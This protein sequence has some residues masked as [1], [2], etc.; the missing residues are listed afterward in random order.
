[1]A[2]LAPSLGAGAPLGRAGA[3]RVTAGEKVTRVVTPRVFGGRT[4]AFRCISP[5][6]M[7]DLPTFERPPK[8]TS[9]I[10]GGIIDASSAADATNSA[11]RTS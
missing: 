4:R 5:F 7:L 6:I 1:M 10:V 9:A 2:H 8:A 3:A 11:L